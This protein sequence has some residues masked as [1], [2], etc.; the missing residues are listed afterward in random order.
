M[1][2]ILENLLKKINYLLIEINKQTKGDPVFFFFLIRQDFSSTRNK[3]Y[4]VLVGWKAKKINLNV[5][6]L[7]N[8]FVRYGKDEK[9]RGSSIN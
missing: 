1:R 8:Y 5:D 3:F 7:I 6:N 2:L 9:F 4:N